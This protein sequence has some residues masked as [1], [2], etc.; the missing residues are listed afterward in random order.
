MGSPTLSRPTTPILLKKSRAR[1]CSVCRYLGPGSDRE[2]NPTTKAW[3]AKN[4]KPNPYFPGSHRPERG[5]DRQPGRSGARGPPSS[6]CTRPRHRGPPL[7]RGPTRPQPHLSRPSFCYLWLL[8]GRKN[9]DRL[10]PRPP[11]PC[12]SASAAAA[13][14]FPECCSPGAGPAPGPCW[15]WGTG[16]DTLPPC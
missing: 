10:F 16:V 4:H 6:R 11:P 1:A 5:R 2:A 7:G 9:R 12:A 15:A 13:R 8:R 14:A 3:K